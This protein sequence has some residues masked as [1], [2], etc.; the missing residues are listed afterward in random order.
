MA[1]L[2]FI[3]GIFII[4]LIARYNE[5]NKLFWVLLISFVGAFT[6]ASITLSLARSNTKNKVDLVQM[7]PTQ[8]PFST[9]SYLLP[10]TDV[11]EMVTYVDLQPTVLAGKDYTFAT[12]KVFFTTND[13]IEMFDKPPQIG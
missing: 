13:V 10:V 8:A 12:N 5:S 9:V 4:F 11:S 1:L 6:V 7:C 3:L 2:W